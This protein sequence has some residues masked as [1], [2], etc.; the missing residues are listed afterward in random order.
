[1]V[2]LHNKDHI[3][4]ILDLFWE[5]VRGIFD[6]EHEIGS[7]SDLL[8]NRSMEMRMKPVGTRQVMLGEVNRVVIRLPRSNLKK[9]GITRRIWRGMCAMPVKIACIWV[10][11]AVYLGIR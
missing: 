9:N 2:L 7:A 1:M 11:E 3:F 5:S 8:G 4:G 10:S 6:N